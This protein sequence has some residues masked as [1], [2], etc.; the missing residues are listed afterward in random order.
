MDHR[1]L[2]VVAVE[3]TERVQARVELEPHARRQEL[4]P[5]GSAALNRSLDPTAELQAL[6]RVVVPGPADLTT[7]HLVANPVAPAAQQQLPVITGRVAVPAANRAVLPTE[8]T[9]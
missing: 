6:A 4:L 3:V 5:R 1:G 2:L 8:F 9:R 7:V